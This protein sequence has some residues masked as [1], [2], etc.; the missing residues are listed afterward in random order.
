[1]LTG[2]LPFWPRLSLAEVAA[3]PPWNL[4]AA[5]RSH[6]IEFPRASWRAV[7]PE[8]QQLAAALL[9]RDPTR[10]I[11]AAEALAH[12]WFR[13]QLGFTPLPSSSASWSR[14]PVEAADD[15]AFTSRVAALHL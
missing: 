13:A 8:A 2:Q 6:D 5:I 3:L 15:V 14:R 9:Q 1:M 7:S 4:M 11:A 10:R 12:P